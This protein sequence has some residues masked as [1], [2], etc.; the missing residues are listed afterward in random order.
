MADDD[1]AVRNMAATKY[2]Y[3][4]QKL[5]YALDMRARLQLVLGY[6]D[7]LVRECGKC[8]SICKTMLDTIRGVVIK[9]G[10]GGYKKICAAAELG[11]RALDIFADLMHQYGDEL[12]S[13]NVSIETY[14]AI[15]QEISKVV[16]MAEEFNTMFVRLYK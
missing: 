13:N 8:H 2:L 7:P 15:K 11:S 4:T 14:S 6:D 9:D 3:N 5:D 10:G 1:V 16:K 12:D